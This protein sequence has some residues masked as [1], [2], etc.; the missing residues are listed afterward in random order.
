M[1]T[2]LR[3]RPLSMQYGGNRC[4]G[5]PGRRCPDHVLTKESP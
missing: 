4:A 5:K 2:A 1:S 3:C